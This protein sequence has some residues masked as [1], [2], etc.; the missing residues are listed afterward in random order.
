M[1]V[2]WCKAEKKIWL[3]QFL[4]IRWKS[5]FRMTIKSDRRCLAIF[6]FAKAKLLLILSTG[7]KTFV[8]DYVGFYENTE[9]KGW[10]LL[11]IDLSSVVG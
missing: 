1:V 5:A 6:Y 3:F 11:S 7:F 8:R 10:T 9:V 2:P 4:N